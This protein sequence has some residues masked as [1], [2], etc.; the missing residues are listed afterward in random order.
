MTT[1][2]HKNV[3]GRPRGDTVKA[4]DVLSDQTIFALD[5]KRFDL[6]T[7]ALDLPPPP[8]RKLK[9]LFVTKAPWE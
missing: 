7:A 6:F 1:S 2:K 4:P 5:P 3:S 8:N 9:A